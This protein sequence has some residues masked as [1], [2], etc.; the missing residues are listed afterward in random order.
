MASKPARGDRDH[1]AN[2]A[3]RLARVDAADDEEDGCRL[4]RRC[5][6]RRWPAQ[7]RSTAPC[8]NGTV[9]KADADAADAQVAVPAL[10]I[11]AVVR[12]RLRLALQRRVGQHVPQVLG[13]Q[14]LVREGLVGRA[15]RAV[16]MKVQVSLRAP[17]TRRGERLM[18]VRNKKGAGLPRAG[19][20]ALATSSSHARLCQFR[21][22]APMRKL[23]RPR[24]RRRAR[25]ACTRGG[26]DHARLRHALRVAAD[27]ATSV[28]GEDVAA[29]A[30]RISP[31]RKI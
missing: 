8:Q 18:C 7:S 11:G 30:P 23:A 1:V 4:T 14:P 16:H 5:T 2:A 10:R 26:D 17:E 9:A 6:G 13:A 12:A 3:R 24:G 25:T 22:R 20:C 21:G 27:G 31:S 29:I 19:Q 15:R 28:E